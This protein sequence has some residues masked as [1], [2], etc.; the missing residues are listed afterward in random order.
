MKDDG[1][2]GGSL[3]LT[4]PGRPIA[5]KNNPQVYCPPNCP[6]WRRGQG[7][8]PKKIVRPSKEYLE[9][10]GQMLKHLMQYM[11]IQ[12]TEPVD[13]IVYYWMPDRRSR[14][15]LAGLLQAT[16]DILEKAEILKNDQLIRK[17]GDSCI[18]GIDKG[19]PRAEVEIV[20]VGKQ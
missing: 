15:D 6:G 16:A 10:E 13:V 14:P 17:W 4:L 9:Y 8:Q 7:K 2:V 3:K 18:I 20:P 19:N 11:N 5:K 1:R 12:F